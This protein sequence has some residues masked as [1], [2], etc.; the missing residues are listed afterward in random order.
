MTSNIENLNYY[1]LFNAPLEVGLRT[2]V[3]LSY[4]KTN[5]YDIDRIV[6]F[7]YFILHARDIDAEQNNLH[8]SLPHRSTEII[9]R[10]KL[11]LEGLEI[12]V[13]KGL[14]DIIYNNAGIFYKSNKMTDLF[15]NLLKSNYFIRL[16][17]LTHWAISKYGEIDTQ[18]LNSLINENVQLWGGEFEFEALVRGNYES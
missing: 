8:P 2:L 13:S 5:D 11:I 1:S 7:D 18:Q 15:V 4:V 10:R 12:L 3:L 16:K 17:N 9:I 6:I 14:V